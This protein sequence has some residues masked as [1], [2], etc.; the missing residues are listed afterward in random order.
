MHQRIP[1]LS[2]AIAITLTL[3]VSAE[4]SARKSAR[5]SSTRKS[6]PTLSTR[7]TISL[8]QRLESPTFSAARPLRVMDRGHMLYLGKGFGR[9]HQ[10]F[11]L[12]RLKDLQKL[13]IT[14]PFHAYVKANPAMKQDPNDT[15]PLHQQ[16]HVEKLLYYDSDNQ[17][18]G[19]QVAD[20]LGKQKVRRHFFVPWDLKKCHVTEPTL[21]A[22]SKVGVS[23]S[24]S[25]PLG[26]DPRL[27]EFFYVRQVIARDSQQRTVFVIG[28]SRKKPRIVAQFKAKRSMGERTYFDARRGR[29]L[30]VEYAE[31]ASP[32]PAPRGHLVTLATGKV[33]SFAIPLTTYGVA[34][35]DDGRRLYTYSS[36]LGKLWTL[37]TTSGARLA[38]LSI[39]KLGHA[40][41]MLG[42]KRLVLLR[43]SGLRLLSS[44]QGRL[45]KGPF[46]KTSRFFRG[47]SHVGG[48]LVVGPT[49][50]LKNDDDLHVLIAKGTSTKA[51]RKHSR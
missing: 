19:F 2:L 27:R 38:Q 37:D 9:D 40:I 28:F 51:K 5:K 45:S 21:V 22:R 8:A 48:S 20:H 12:L 7:K 44:D 11:Y 10:T 15:R 36:Q 47:F 1:S 3:L 4:S 49:I 43:N 34:F 41:G 32:K 17:Q 13:K 31:L 33:M 35:D 30:L 29:A 14:A 25:L 26:Y 46:I 24:H 50:L 23:Y 6:W 39:G 42:A 18:A 16:F